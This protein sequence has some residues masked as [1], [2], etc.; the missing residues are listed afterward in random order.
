MSQY[1]SPNMLQFTDGDVECVFEPG[2]GTAW[3]LYM[4]T[5]QV[6]RVVAHIGREVFYDMIFEDV[7]SLFT[8]CLMDNK[9]RR[10]VECAPTLANW[11]DGDE[12]Y[13]EAIEPPTIH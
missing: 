13:G 9:V 3:T 8:E 2:N 12:V 1:I 10:L 4:N 6:F 5:F 7:I 11:N